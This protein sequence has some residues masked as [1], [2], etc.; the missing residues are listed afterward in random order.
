MIEIQRYICLYYS[1]AQCVPLVANTLQKGLHLR[2]RQ[3]THKITID[4]ALS[5]A[6]FTNL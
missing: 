3:I 6:A 5:N 1:F 2:S 4:M